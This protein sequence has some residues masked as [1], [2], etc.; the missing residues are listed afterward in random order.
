MDLHIND[1]VHGMM[2]L[3]GMAREMIDTPELQRLRNIKQLGLA[4]LV[5]PGAH[6]SRLEHGLGTYHIAGTMADRLGLDGGDR[7]LVTS[8][9][10]LHDIGHIP[11]S[12]TF[13]SVLFNKLRLDH[14]DIT[15]GLIEG[16]R[17][18][19]DV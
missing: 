9:A 14:M 13:E 15:V 5:F 6:H 11:F 12:H 19:S 18:I 17:S 10:L 3:D 2:V 4:D 16:T 7:M 8:A 1:P